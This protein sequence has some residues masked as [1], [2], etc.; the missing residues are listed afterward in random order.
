MR[1]VIGQYAP[2]RGRLNVFFFL[3][4]LLAKKT[5]SWNFLRFDFKKSLT[6]HKFCQSYE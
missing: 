4:S 1:K 6:Y 5:K 2:L 3:L